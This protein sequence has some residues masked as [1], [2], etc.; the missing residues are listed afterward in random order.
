MILIFF[1]IFDKPKKI[2]ESRDTICISMYSVFYR[3]LYIYYAKRSVNTIA[4]SDT[5]SAIPITIRKLPNPFPVS[6]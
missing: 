3:S 2:T 6:A 1:F 4:K 5:V